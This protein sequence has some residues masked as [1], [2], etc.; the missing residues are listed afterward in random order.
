MRPQLPPEPTPVL[1]GPK[2]QQHWYR[3]LQEFWESF[4]W[5]AKRPV[6]DLLYVPVNTTGAAS[7]TSRFTWTAQLPNTY[8]PGT[9]IEVSLLWRPNVKPDGDIVFSL[10]YTVG[11]IGDS[12]ATDVT[13]TVTTTGATIDILYELE[14]VDIDGG[15]LERG[16]VLEGQVSRSG[17]DPD[18]TNTQTVFMLG[19][20]LKYRIEGAGVET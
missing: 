12:L 20:M 10:V 17:S 7:G 8:K 19:L 6:Y 9:D 13:E 5:N 1:S 3:F 15:D 4:G 18:D 2:F 16:D 11:G 14:F